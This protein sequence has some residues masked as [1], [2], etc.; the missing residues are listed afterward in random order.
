MSDVKYNYGQATTND[1]VCDE[2][3]KQ[4]FLNYATEYMLNRAVPFI[5]DGLK[6][7]HRRILFDIYNV[8]KITTTYVKSAKIAGNIIATTHPH[9][10]DAVYESMIYLSQPWKMPYPLVEVHGNKGSVDGDQ[11]AAARYT[12]SRVSAYGQALAELLNQIEDEK[13]WKITELQDGNLE[14]VYFPTLLPNV[15][16]NGG[17]GISVKKFDVPPFNLSEICEL[18]IKHAEHKDITKT[19]IYPDFGDAGGVF[20]APIS[21]YAEKSE[22]K[23][24][25]ATGDGTFTMYGTIVDDPNGLAI[26]SIPWGVSGAT[27]LD[28]LVS[29]ADSSN[30]KYVNEIADIQQ[31]S[32]KAN[33]FLIKIKLK[34]GA[35]REKVKALI[36][37][38]THLQTTYRMMANIVHNNYVSKLSIYE[39]IKASVENGKNYIKAIYTKLIKDEKLELE[40]IEGLLKLRTVLDD[41][42]KLVK[43]SKDRADV[44]A[45]L[46]KMGFTER[47]SEHIA[48]LMLHKL[49]KD[50]SENW[51]KREKELKTLIKEQEAIIKNDDLLV[52]DYVARMKNYIKS[53]GRQ[54]ITV[55]LDK[56]IEI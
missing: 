2:L 36:Y 42:I 5:E 17:T 24:I 44:V 3:E 37:Q 43:K 31:L 10:S 27:V 47:Q 53:F 41:V 13:L 34:R 16:I 30:K 14:P 49:A 22:W 50:N 39:I 55:V 32:S 4:N 9:S 33:G 45:G 15:L 12:E 35:D 56:A 25:N 51:V 38:R 54:R 6:P 48:N 20:K 40:I 8:E 52:K 29:L 11:C 19:I 28:D 21:V 23:N 18:C 46:V 26:L 1:V 7:I